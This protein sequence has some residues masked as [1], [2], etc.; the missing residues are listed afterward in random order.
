M[1]RLVRWFFVWLLCFLFTIP[2]AA[3]ENGGIC[4]ALGMQS[5]NGVGIA[6][7]DLSFSFDEEKEKFLVNTT[8][9]LENRGQASDCTLFLPILGDEKIDLFVDEKEFSYTIYKLYP[10]NVYE[11]PDFSALGIL[12]ALQ[13]AKEETLETFLSQEVLVYTALEDAQKIELYFPQE[14]T[15][16]LFD[17]VGVLSVSPENTG[18]Y[19]ASAAVQEKDASIACLTAE[20]TLRYEGAAEQKMT[21]QE[22]ID[23]IRTKEGF[24]KADMDFYRYFANRLEKQAGVVDIACSVAGISADYENEIYLCAA[25]FSIPFAF[26]EQ[27]TVSL[28]YEILP[29]YDMTMQEQFE[30]TQTVTAQ[31]VADTAAKWDFFELLDIT[32]WPSTSYTQ[33]ISSSVPFTR[34]DPGNFTA[35]FYG[36]PEDRI[37]FSLSGEQLSLLEGDGHGEKA[38]EVPLPQQIDKDQTVLYVLRNTILIAVGILLFLAAVLY[39]IEQRKRKQKK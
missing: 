21:I 17:G 26:K 2:A 23:K 5:G 37:S 18:G 1:Q 27:H 31:Y 14:T 35:A 15:Q 29:N 20:E 22:Y 12:E 39:Q 11:E 16:L 19:A 3:Q 28:S 33:M 8:Y 36:L 10:Y 6:S 34:E 9:V 38:Q 4:F 30:Y 25:E 24:K 13:A 32:V 7:Q